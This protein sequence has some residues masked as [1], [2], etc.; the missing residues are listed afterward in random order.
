LK[1]KGKEVRP[2]QIATAQQTLP[3]L[4]MTKSN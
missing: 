2:V 3:L 1:L 4:S